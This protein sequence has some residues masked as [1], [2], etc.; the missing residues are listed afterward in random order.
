MKKKH[1]NSQKRIHIRDGCYFLTS[2]TKRWYP[3]F[4]EKIFCEIFIENLRLCRALKQFRLYGW[5]L[6]YNNFH[7]L[8]QPGDEWDVSKIMKSLKENVSYMINQIISS[9]TEGETLTSRL[10]W[11]RI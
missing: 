3:F 2:N 9:S 7:L 1:R 8:I 10:Q 4:T 6:D 5:F 11:R